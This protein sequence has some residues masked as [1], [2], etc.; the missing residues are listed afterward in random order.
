MRLTQLSLTNFRAFKQ[1]QTIDF[2]PLTLLFGANSVGKSSVL[3]ALFYLQ[4]LITTREC[5][6][7]R[8]RALGSK[9]VG[10]FP[11]LVN[12]KKLPNSIILKI[13]YEKETSVSGSS[14]HQSAGFIEDI[15]EQNRELAEQ[16]LAISSPSEWANSFDIELQIDWHNSS[17]SAYV[18][19]YTVWVD[20]EFIAE[21]VSDEPKQNAS[22]HLINYLHPLLRCDG[23]LDEADSTK[24][25][26]FHRWVLESGTSLPQEVKCQYT[27][28]SYAHTLF[29]FH[30]ESGAL[31]KLG[32][33]LITSLESSSPLNTSR[34]NE[35]F[36]DLFVAPLDNLATILNDSLSIGPIR[37]IPD[38]Y[39]GSDDYIQQ[40]DWYNGEA[41]WDVIQNADE[42]LIQ[43]CNRWLG[44]S[45]LDL[46]MALVKKHKSGDVQYSLDNKEIS[47]PFQPQ[48]DKVV[49]WDLQH[50]IEV[51]PADV[52]AGVAQLFPL[53][54]AANQSRKGI[55]CCEQ[56]E[57]H[58]HPKVQVA[59]G[60]LL[61]Q[62]QTGNQ[63]LIE[64]HSEHLV[65]RLLRRIRESEQN[66]Q[67]E[68]FRPV[69]PEDI[70]L[71]YLEQSNA[72][73]LVVK[74]Q[75]T[76]DGDLVQDWPNGF[77]EERDEELF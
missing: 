76:S 39:Y 77:F 73:T 20:E 7:K 17:E 4:E 57:L 37:R 21:A 41:S 66:N 28:S 27:N 50:N 70:S 43:Q 8:I 2:A 13:R 1:T 24:T 72:G 51:T 32:H 14:Y 26:E 53:V 22:V 34:I 71:I 44:E 55:V 12:E 59:I 36:S 25:G 48:A 9:Y 29:E 54:I 23:E 33:P 18:S 16:Y 38:Q 68:G 60:D 11:H 61:M 10:G 19:R 65:L 5:S 3:M 74:T 58:V 35:V 15:L 47:T 42:K 56:P 40:M 63:F 46:D 52:G 62:C 64:T 75:I 30:S 49:L 6:P 69:K 45:N 31:P 67:P